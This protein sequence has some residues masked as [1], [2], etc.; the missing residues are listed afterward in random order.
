MPTKPEVAVPHMPCRPWN[1]G[2][3]SLHTFLTSFSCEDT[4]HATSGW[5]GALRWTREGLGIRI[6]FEHVLCRMH[7]RR[8]RALQPINHMEAKRE[9]KAASAGR[10][11]GRI[12]G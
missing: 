10:M 7:T 2:E 12:D 9:E 3:R 5:E 4:P 11:D 6:A 1:S 8:G